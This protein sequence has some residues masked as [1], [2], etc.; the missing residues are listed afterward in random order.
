[1]NSAGYERTASGMSKASLLRTSL[2]ELQKNLV[3]EEN[4]GE[5]PH[6]LH[7]IG[8]AYYDLYKE[9][10]VRN[11]FD[12]ALTFMERSTFHGVCVARFNYN[13]GRLFTEIGDHHAALKQYD[14]A[15]RCDPRHIL[16]LS[17]AGTCSYF[18][19]GDR[20]SAAGYF[21]RALGVDSAMPMCHL[22][23]GHIAL[24]EKDYQSARHEFEQ[25]VVA[26]RS[27]LE[28]RR[29]PISTGNIRY[30]ASIAHLNL[31]ILY[32]TI[33]L[34]RSKAADHLNRY[35]EFETDQQKKEKASNDFGK[36]WGG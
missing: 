30:S 31:M 25:E 34:D 36:F 20:R 22:V 23:L 6:I 3:E 28:R 29:Y 2:A 5:K 4:P 14:E 26:D 9:T 35:F 1:L 7:N 12:S 11:L 33:F 16:A 21:V 18:A 17:N 19:F 32:S 10:G 13:I 24:D 27:S 8:C 15:L